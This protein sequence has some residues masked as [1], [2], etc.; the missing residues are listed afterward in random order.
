MCVCIYIHT[1]TYTHMR[2]DT[3]AM[4]N[5]MCGAPAGAPR[6]SEQIYVKIQD[7][8]R[9]HIL[10]CTSQS[11]CAVVSHIHMTINT[12]AQVLIIFHN[13]II[14]YVSLLLRG[15]PAGASRTELHMDLHTQA[16]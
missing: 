1:H 14:S 8:Q 9:N 5:A 13:N 16:T 10:Q 12:N 11:Q 6:C 4:L 2:T 15:A 3:F 7:T